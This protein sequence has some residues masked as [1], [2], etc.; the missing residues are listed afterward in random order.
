MAL[1][2]PIREYPIN[3]LKIALHDMEQRAISAESK[4]GTR[5]S[6][7]NDLIAFNRHYLGLP[8]DVAKEF[9]EILAR[10]REALEP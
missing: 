3:Q 8:M 6:I 1:D 2:N 10:A 9:D 7:L 5:D 4:L